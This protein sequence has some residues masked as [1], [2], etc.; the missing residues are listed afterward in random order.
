MSS[1]YHF[2]LLF[3]VAATRTRIHT[4]THTNTYTLLYLIGYLQTYPHYF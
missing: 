3:F 1:L 4:H 2:I